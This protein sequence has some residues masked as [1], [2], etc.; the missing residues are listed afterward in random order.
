MQRKA[1]LRDSHFIDRDVAAH[2]DSARTLIDDDLRDRIRHHRQ[3]LQAR[4]KAHDV[5]LV[6]SRDADIDPARVAGSCHI[7]ILRI[8]RPRD[9]RGRREIRVAQRQRQRTIPAEIILDRALDNGAIRRRADRREILLD[10]VATAAGHEAAR[11][12]RALRD[13]IDNAIRRL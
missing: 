8:D 13:S 1:A 7:A 10:V 3:V 2:D 6:V 5:I 4:D 9:A 12:D 11:R